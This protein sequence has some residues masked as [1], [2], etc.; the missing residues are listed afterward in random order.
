MDFKDHSIQ[1]YIYLADDDSDDRDLFVEAMMEV[2][3]SIIIRQAEDGI[4]LMDKLLT[5]SK[6]ELP[7]YIFID[8]NMPRK[9]GF[10]CLEEIRNHKG[11]LKE[12]N[13]I[14]FSTSNARETIQRAMEMGATFYAVKP[15]TYEK[16]KSLMENILHMDLVS[17]FDEKRKFLLA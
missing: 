11:N 15:S 3:P 14:V 6:A 8:I 17:T 2:D 12:L 7:E 16:L 9:S 10:E 5:L 4:D 13:V 1:R